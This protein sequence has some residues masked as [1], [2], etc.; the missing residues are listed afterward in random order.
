M[1]WYTAVVVSVFLLAG[2]AF[3]ADKASMQTE[4]QK[5]S[6]AMGLSLGKYFKELEENFDLNLVQQ[7]IKDGY[8]DAKPLLTDEEAQEIQQ[9]F[10]KRQHDKQVQKTVV[11]IQKN[12]KAADDFLAANKGKDGV[13]TTASG[14]QYK[15]V[16]EGKGAKPKPEDMVRV[17]YKG[18]TLDNEEFDSSYKRNEPAE[19]MVSQVIPGWQEALPLMSVGS[20]FELYLPPDL[21]YGDRG[22]PPA[23]EP[24]SLLIFDVELLD[25][26]KE[27]PKTEAD[28]VEVKPEEKK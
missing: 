15:I 10:A 1:K 23:I 21:A 27:E 5:F 18:R 4:E 19:F 13:Q 14:L 28:K 6:Y 8:G 9:N 24:G 17:H 11:M 2:A 12:R 16:K 26:I 7:G 25:I 22:A 3:A 20:T